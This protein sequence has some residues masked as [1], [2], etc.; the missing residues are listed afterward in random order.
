MVTFPP[1]LASSLWY[2]QWLKSL[3]QD[4]SAV[5]AMGRANLKVQDPRVFARTAISP[6]ITLS[7]PIEGGGRRLRSFSNI[8]T[9]H[10]SEH[11][12][13]RK[14][15]FGALETEFG[16]YPFFSNFAEGLKVV[17]GD[18]G[19]ETLNDFNMK[20]HHLLAGTLIGDLN[21]ED[22]NL[23]FSN[24]VLIKRG[25]EFAREIIGEE[26]VIVPLMKFG[27]ETLTGL[28]AL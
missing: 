6:E 25:K 26:S 13:W 1:Y 20:I 16:R 2:S 7:I 5:K 27:K 11:G 4:S 17:Y 18:R 10:L 15:H 9:A 8:E 22:I 14:N 21:Y 23:F 19:V 24:D 12:N 3:A 28:L